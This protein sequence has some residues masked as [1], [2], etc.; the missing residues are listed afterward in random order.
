M[1]RLGYLILIIGLLGLGI[2]TPSSALYTIQQLQCYEKCVKDAS[3]ANGGQCN[4]VCKS[5]CLSPCGITNTQNSGSPP[6][7]PETLITPLN[8]SGKR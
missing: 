7:A 5:G 8:R 2:A 3:T 6:Q 1:L 4:A